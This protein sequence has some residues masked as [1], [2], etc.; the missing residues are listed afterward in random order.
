MVC[1]PDSH[2]TVYEWLESLQPHG[3]VRAV[4]RT[5]WNGQRREADTYRY[6]ETIPLR[7]GE[8]ALRV[9]WCEIT[10]TDE[11]GDRRYH[12]AFA[13]SLAINSDNVAEGGEAGRS[14]WKI[15]NE[16]NNTLKTQGY[17]FEHHLGHGQPHWSSLLASLIILAFGVHTAL[18]WTDEKPY[19]S[20]RSP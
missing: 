13:T 19:V 17:H 20:S 3:A 11:K 15:E 2:A 6:A 12:N 7:D 4:V 14:R 10:T 16:N 8:D 18:E 1:Q 9:N 5:R